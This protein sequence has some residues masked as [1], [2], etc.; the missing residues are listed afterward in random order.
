MGL[1]AIF[2]H[3]EPAVKRYSRA[4]AVRQAARGFAEAPPPAKRARPRAEPDLFTSRQWIRIRSGVAPQS[5]IYFGGWCNGSTADSGSV[6]LGSN[7]SPPVGPAGKPSRRGQN[8]RAHRAEAEPPL[9]P[10][11]AAASRGL[12]RTGF[13]CEHFCHPAGRW[14]HPQTRREMSLGMDQRP[15]K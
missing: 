15:P 10:L 13:I 5:R 6:C 12:P 9:S 8:A 1:G 3:R 7:P 14:T 4:G 2:A 11:N